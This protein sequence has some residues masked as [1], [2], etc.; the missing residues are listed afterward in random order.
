MEIEVG[1]FVTLVLGETRASGR[2]RGYRNTEDGELEVLWLGGISEGFYVFEGWKV[3][4]H[5]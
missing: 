5:G 4:V 2:L 3:E 1:E